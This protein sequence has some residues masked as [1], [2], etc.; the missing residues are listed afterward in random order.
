MKKDT[1]QHIVRFLIK[2]LTVSEYFG[3]ENVPKEGGVILAINHMSHLDT[4][5]MMV[6]PVRPDITALVTTKYGE[7]LFVAWLTNTAGGIWINRD[8]A[9]FSAI[10][11]AAKALNEGVALGIAPEG[12][13]SKNGQLQAGKPG[14]LM[15]AVKTGAPIVPV[16]ITG[17]ETALH[18]LA[19]FRRPRL[20]VRFGKPFTI[21]PLERGSRSQDLKKWT[22]ELMLRIAAL[23][24]KSYRGIYFDQ[25]LK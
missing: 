11:K 25:A 17:T 7:N 19:H 5:L 10:R 22:R 2:T 12:T 15:L 8:I 24:P 18:D 4:P 16:G 3:T 21:P 14:T 20:T 13:R 9:D 1:L 6:N 23:L